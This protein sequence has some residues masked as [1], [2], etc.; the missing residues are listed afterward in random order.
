MRGDI[1]IGSQVGRYRIDAPISRGGMGVVYRATDIALER[2]VALKVISPELASDQGFRERFRRESKIA[3]GLDHPNVIPVYEAGEGDGVLF[4]AMRFI[5]GTDLK[6]VIDER[7]GL[8]PLL[9]ARLT[10]QLGGALDT[11]H[12]AGL[13]H[14]DVSR[15]T[16]S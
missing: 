7:A 6:D 16:C 14:R 13:V 11:A 2:S 15:R 1:T 9:A 10:A 12:A 4:L 3:A 8:E 5:D